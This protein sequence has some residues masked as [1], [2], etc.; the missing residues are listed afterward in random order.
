MSL[1]VRRVRTQPLTHRITSYNVCYTKLL[2]NNDGTYT[3]EETL[4]VETKAD[5]TKLYNG[6]EKAEGKF[7]PVGNIK[8]IKI[9]GQQVAQTGALG[10]F[11]YLSA[12]KDSTIVSYNFV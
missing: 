4:F 8:E 6:A 10:P 9:D 12:V 3:L 1:P 7:F 2:R 5:G 11:A